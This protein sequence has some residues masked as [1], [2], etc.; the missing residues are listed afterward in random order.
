[1]NGLDIIRI[2]S[3]GLD[4]ITI[5]LSKLFEIHCSLFESSLEILVKMSNT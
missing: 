1:M 3:D 5:C 4:I 2:K